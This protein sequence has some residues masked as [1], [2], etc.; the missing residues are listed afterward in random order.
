MSPKAPRKFA[1][2]QF[3]VSSSRDEWANGAWKSPVQWP[4]WSE[5]SEIKSTDNRGVFPQKNW[6]GHLLTET[7]KRVECFNMHEIKIQC[8]H[9]LLHIGSKVS[10]ADFRGEQVRNSRIMGTWRC[11]C[12][13]VQTHPS[14]IFW[15]SPSYIRIEH[16]ALTSEILT[17]CLFVLSLNWTMP[18]YDWAV[19]TF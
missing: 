12:T 16:E 8:T 3:L 18:F 17:L 14:L 10:L 19:V 1:K 6:Q 2:T 4:Q 11:G 9:K 5:S 7:F 15:D 13:V